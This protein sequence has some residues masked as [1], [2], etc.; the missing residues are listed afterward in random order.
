MEPPNRITMESIIAYSHYEYEN[1]PLFI[2]LAGTPCNR[3]W[4]PNVVDIIASL[5][6]W[7]GNTEQETTEWALEFEIWVRSLLLDGGIILNPKHLALDEVKDEFLELLR[8]GRG[9]IRARY[10]RM[11]AVDMSALQESWEAAGKP[12]C[13]DYV[14][15]KWFG[16]EE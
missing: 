9:N 7:Y 2:L 14:T 15:D 3:I 4:F 16:R 10:E 6:E 13:F 12:E 5:D 8:Y 1:S 11:S